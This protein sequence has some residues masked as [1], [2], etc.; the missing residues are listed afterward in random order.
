MPKINVLPREIYE[1]IAAGEVVERPSSA[2]KELMENSIDAGST[3][4]TV[5]IKNG[6]IKYIRV[7]D[8][9]C[10]IAREDIANAFV[11]HATSKIARSGDLDAVS[12]LGFRGEALASI[13]A[14]SRVELLTRTPEDET[15]TLCV[16]EGGTILSIDDA[17]CP[18]GTTIVVRDIF[19]NVPARMKF[20]KKDTTEANSVAAVAERVAISHPEVS[21]RLIRDG[22]QVLFSPGDGKLISA[23]RAVYGADF[24]E[25]LMAAFGENGSVKVDGYVSKPLSA[26]PNRNM[27]IF[28]VNGRMVRT[29]T[30]MAA[31]EEAYK[32]SIMTGKF[33]ACVLNISVPY[34]FVDVNVHPAK[35]EVRFANEKEVFGAVYYAAKTAVEHGA[36][37]HTVDPT[38][39]I[40]RRAAQDWL[41]ALAEKGTQVRMKLDG[42]VNAGAGFTPKTFSEAEK[43]AE[44]AE[45]PAAVLRNDAGPSYNASGSEPDV[46]DGFIPDISPKNGG[47]A[48]ESAPREP[49]PAD[50]NKPAKTDAEEALPVTFTTDETPEARVIGELFRTYILVERGGELLMIDKHAAHERMLYEQYKRDHGEVPSQLMLMPLTV[51]LSREEYRAVV[52]NT[53]LLAQAG[54]HVEDFGEGTVL[55]SEYPVIL[56]DTDL[57]SQL[58]EIAGYLADNA[59]AVTTEKIDWIYHSAACRA[60]VKAGDVTGREELEA[61]ARSVLDSPD[62]RYCPHGRPV[63]ARLK[64]S[65]IEKLF[66]RIV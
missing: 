50:E 29:K 46:L 5:E 62:I 32:G 28:F 49:L 4:V 58:T 1:L 56:Q 27:Q 15:G 44:K 59:K 61:F 65:D 51:R 31:L 19:Y 12:T 3:S 7:T 42:P 37:S 33:P 60:A 23:V 11:S 39:I 24:T 40:N 34:A 2:V 14:V 16:N 54:F 25:G 13:A 63:L 35:T 26:R 10:G 48:A 45:K 22:K 47:D 55:L 38:S 57:A 21:V 66:G 43:P 64:K 6:G 17:G 30:A 41:S 20:L 18:V 52:D 53:E 36:G 8:N 9:G